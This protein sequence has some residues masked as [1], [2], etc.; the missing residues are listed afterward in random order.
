MTNVRAT[1]VQHV[2]LD[3]GVA[4]RVQHLRSRAEQVTTDSLVFAEALFHAHDTDL[5]QRARTSDG[6]C[7]PSEEEFWE[8]A[9]GIKRRTGFQLLA[10]GKTLTALQLPPP[11][12]AALAVI[13]LHKLDVILP[14]LGTQGTV[15]TTRTWIS[16]A[17]R[18]LATHSA[19][20]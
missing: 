2:A 10:R 6:Q 20:V 3:N 16:L 13:G 17:R 8:H 11:E 7:Y 14:V 1:P 18:C 19:S 5:W 12:R 4:H 15:E 9:L